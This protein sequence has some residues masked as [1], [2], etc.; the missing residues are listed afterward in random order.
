M[1]L[2][3][4]KRKNKL[5]GSLLE[6]DCWCYSCRLTCLIHSL[7]AYFEEMQTGHK[8]LAKITPASALA[9]VRSFLREL[10]VANAGKYRIPDW[11]RCRAKIMQMSGNTLYQIM[12]TGEWRSPSFMS[13]MEL[14]EFEMG[15]TMEAH[16]A[17]SSSK[18][19]SGGE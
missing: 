17:E 9:R 3:S 2:K 12:M 10:G 4:A 7:W 14:M 8:A 16:M 6:G 13:Y 11:R 18:D 5:H 19:E 1:C 15:A